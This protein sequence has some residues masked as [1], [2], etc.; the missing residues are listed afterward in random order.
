MLLWIQEQNVLN[1]D[2]EE[3][4]SELTSFMV[5]KDQSM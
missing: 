3:E 1:V 5:R 4:I 2:L